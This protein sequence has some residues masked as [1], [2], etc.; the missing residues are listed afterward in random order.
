MSY[1][2][3]SDNHIRHQVRIVF[4]LSNYTT[5]TNKKMLQVLTCGMNSLKIKVD[6]LDFDKSKT[7]PVHLKKV[8][9]L[10][11]KNVV[12]ENRLNTNKIPDVSTLIQKKIGD[13]G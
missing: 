2:P 12:N 5:K 9:H 3:E 7:V 8:S 13:V 1:S 10:M 11:S 6:D 4:E